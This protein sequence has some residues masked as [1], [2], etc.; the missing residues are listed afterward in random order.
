MT[1]IAFPLPPLG[2]YLTLLLSRQRTRE[3]VPRNEEPCSKGG[4]AEGTICTSESCS[5]MNVAEERRSDLRL[6]GTKKARK[7]QPILDALP[8]IAKTKKGLVFRRHGV[9]SFGPSSFHVYI[10]LHIVSFI[11]KFL[12]P[13]AEL[14]LQHS[15]SHSQERHNQNEH[16][17]HIDQGPELI[18]IIEE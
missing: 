14:M 7:L 17:T 10:I 1:G 11:S 6:H 4:K 8:C 9:V 5:C 12:S 18:S 15:L 13:P 3:H 16:T 2:S